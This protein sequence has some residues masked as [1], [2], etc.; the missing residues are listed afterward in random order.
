MGRLCH[1]NMGDEPVNIIY[2]GWSKLDRETDYN[3]LYFT[4][5]DWPFTLVYAM[6]IDE[7]VLI[8]F[9][10]AHGFIGEG[11]WEF[12]CPICNSRAIEDSECIDDDDAFAL[13]TDI[14]TT[15]GKSIE[16]WFPPFI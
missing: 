4:Y 8:P 16:T 13:L 15:Q 3:Y 14:L 1:D 10:L 9:Y 11:F 2:R 6:L 5:Q 12:V 7:P